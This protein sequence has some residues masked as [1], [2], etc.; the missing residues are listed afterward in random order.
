MSAP[1]FAKPIELAEA[2]RAASPR[3]G[4]P[5]LPQTDRSAE[6]GELRTAAIL[7]AAASTTMSAPDPAHPIE[8]AEALRAASPRS[9]NTPPP[10]DAK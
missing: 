7:A 4:K 6:Q 5:A 3:S 10:Q 2:L 8:L 9:G 1:D